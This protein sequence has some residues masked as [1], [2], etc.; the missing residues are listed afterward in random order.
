MEDGTV[1]LDHK[2]NAGLRYTYI[3]NAPADFSENLDTSP[4]SSHPVL[5]VFLNGLMLPQIGWR[6][7]LEA[8]I[9]N[10][11]DKN[12]SRPYMLS[13]DRYGQGDSDPDPLD[14]VPGAEKGH[15]HDA[16]DAVKD[17]HQLISHFVSKKLN[18]PL[19]TPSATSS[20]PSQ[21]AIILVANSIGAAIARLYAYEYPNTVSGILLLD[22]I[23]SNTDFTSLFPDVDAPSF[24]PSTLPPGITSD[25]VRT[26]REN[27]TAIF[28]PSVP[29]KEGLSRRNL[30]SLLP[31]PSEPSLVGPGGKGP[32]LTV[33]GHDPETFAEQGLVGSMQ[34]PVEITKTYVQP[35][36]G[37]YNEGL[38]GIT[39]EERTRGVVVAKGCGHF[40]QRDDPDFVV[41]EIVSLVGLMEADMKGRGKN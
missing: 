2:P 5:L 32:R 10:V 13:Y 11:Q 12:Q 38:L 6:P 34:T 3:S 23:I 25:Q 20:S 33:V 15:A 8:L 31:S 35:V 41:G 37:R 27:Y 21:P 24:D 18:L 7:T 26:A 19:S 30:A 17:L 4:S 14:A 16:R 28:H 29:N 40:I 1:Y 36:W 39:G 9:Q 22:S